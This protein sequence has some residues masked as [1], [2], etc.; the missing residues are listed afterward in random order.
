MTSLVS[1]YK[2][3]LLTKETDSRGKTSAAVALLEELNH[4]YEAGD[5]AIYEII[6]DVN[7]LSRLMAQEIEPFIDLPIMRNE[8]VVTL[9]INALYHESEL[10]TNVSAEKDGKAYAAYEVLSRIL[11]KTDSEAKIDFNNKTRFSDHI[12][13]AAFDVLR[14]V[15]FTNRTPA[16]SS[17]DAQKVDGTLTKASQN[18]PA[19]KAFL[20]META[21][22][23]K[24]QPKLVVT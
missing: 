19:V 11:E 15:F 10:L 4:A 14:N 17:D 3:K 18:D 7:F 6:D 22:R 13:V 21:Q 8:A 1:L 12:R 20:K 2:G 23:A 24:A 9:F 16:F 5:K